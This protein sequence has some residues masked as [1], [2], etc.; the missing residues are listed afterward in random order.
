[1]GRENKNK[2]LHQPQ[3]TNH[4]T[5]TQSLACDAIG[6]VVVVAVGTGLDMSKKGGVVVDNE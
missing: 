3:P 4:P 1:M 6:T 2:T 5:Q